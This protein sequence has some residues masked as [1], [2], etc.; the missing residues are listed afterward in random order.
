MTPPDENRK[1]SP[2]ER[3]RSILSAEQDDE[4][5]P[6]ARKPA[7]VNLPRLN[8]DR[9]Q[10]RRRVPA[11]DE[12]KCPV[13]APGTGSR[14]MRTFWTVGA[15]LSILANFV[16]LGLLLGRNGIPG[17]AGSDQ[18]LVA[19]YSSLEQL[20]NAHIR[21][22]I[23]IQSDLSL[24]TTVPVQTTT[25]ITLASDLLVR[26]AHVT[27]NASGLSIDAPADIT[28][29]AG[30]EMDVNL[31]LVLPIKAALPA[32]ADI[33][34]DIAIRDTELHAA[35]QALKDSLRPQVCAQSP[36]AT[37]ADGTPICR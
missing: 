35:I 27:I 26:G 1:G 13:E 21:A 6:E 22:S 36:G 28:L 14:L 7:V 34:V 32:T 33:P 18:A 23:P 8:A 17:S 31:D 10:S 2:R 30:T 9:G 16:L 3:F 19:V 24:D 15:G 29:P 4:P 5:A 25:R 20:D 11:D 37:L 12:P